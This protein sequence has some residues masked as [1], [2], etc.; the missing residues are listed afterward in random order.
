MQAKG[1]ISSEASDCERGERSK[2]ASEAKLR[3]SET[4][5]QAKRDETRQARRD[6]EQS[7]PTRLQAKRSETRL[8]AKRY[9]TASEVELLIT[10]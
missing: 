7:K 10:R 3:V 1:V 9:E 5:L 8:R 4:G 6:C 2:A